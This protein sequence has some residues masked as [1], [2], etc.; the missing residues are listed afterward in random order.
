MER[1]P[2]SA[3]HL[4]LLK[5]TGTQ[6]RTGK[7]NS[8]LQFFGEGLAGLQEMGIQFYVEVFYRAVASR[9]C[10]YIDRPA[11]HCF[12]KKTLN[13]LDPFMN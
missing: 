3:P 12:V 5:R 4:H 7:I 2:D 11:V 10:D 6:E 8:F 13:P 9:V 1:L